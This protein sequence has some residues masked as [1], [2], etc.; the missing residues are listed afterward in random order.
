MAECW[1]MRSQPLGSLRAAYSTKYITDSKFRLYIQESQKGGNRHHGQA[2][3]GAAMARSALHMI[4]LTQPQ[5][6]SMRKSFTV[7][8][9]F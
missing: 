1:R 6:L 3:C 9:T 7:P 8:A 4:C 5:F 2:D